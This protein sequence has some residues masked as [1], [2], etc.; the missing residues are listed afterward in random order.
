MNPPTN[1]D[2]NGQG[3]DKVGKY[4]QMPP[5]QQGVT[6]PGPPGGPKGPIRRQGGGRTGPRET[7]GEQ[8]LPHN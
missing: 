6:G 3:A 4:V 2:E 7:G 1:G 8:P 5:P